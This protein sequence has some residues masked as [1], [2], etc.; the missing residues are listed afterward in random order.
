MFIEKRNAFVSWFAHQ[1]IIM[2]TEHYLDTRYTMVG[3][4]NGATDCIP[5]QAS[6][7]LLLQLPSERGKEKKIQGSGTIKPNVVAS[8]TA[9]RP[10]VTWTQFLEQVVPQAMDW[11]CCVLPSL[12]L[13]VDSG[14]PMS[15]QY[16]S[17]HT[18]TNMGRHSFRFFLQFHFHSIVIVP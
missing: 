18:G 7:K 11:M 13:L 5:F 10:C 16:F 4:I 15:S 6:Q 17:H 3:W 9:G 12:G 2:W 14:S 1:L 8:T